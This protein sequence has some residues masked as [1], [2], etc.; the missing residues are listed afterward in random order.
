MSFEK[1]RISLDYVYN[2]ITKDTAELRKLLKMPNA[3]FY[4]NL[5][6]LIQQS[7]IKRRQVA[8]RPRALN[9]NDEESICL[10]AVIAPWSQ[11]CK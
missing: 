11:L 1:A 9:Q 5:K 8:G 7:R 2:H 6:K 10:K 3:T 4:R